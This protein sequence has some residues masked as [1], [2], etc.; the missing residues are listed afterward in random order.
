MDMLQLV[1]AF[2]NAPLFATFLLGMFWRRTTGHAAFFG[3][4]SGMLAAALITASH[5]RR[6][7]RARQRRLARP[8][9]AHLPE[10]DGAEFLDGH[11]RL[12]RLFRGHDPDF[13][14]HATAEVRR[15]SS[16]VSFR[17]SPRAPPRSDVV[18]YTAGGYRC[19]VLV[20]ALI[21]NILFW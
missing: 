6:A 5:S 18:W 9:R 12:D 19:A 8:C 10:R 21:L 20:L 11:L 1:F 13:A 2:V 4:L 15:R 16:P 14:G 7:P 3:L 17:R